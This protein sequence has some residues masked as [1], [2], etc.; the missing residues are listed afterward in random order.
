M[1]TSLLTVKEVTTYLRIGTSTFYRIMKR[2]EIKPV[3]IG[4]RTLFDPEDVKKFVD[5]RKMK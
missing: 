4:G 2:G 3:K 1:D 5:C